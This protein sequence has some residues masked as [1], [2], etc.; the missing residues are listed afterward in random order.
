MVLLLVIDVVRQVFQLAPADG[1]ISVASL[2]KERAI[3]LAA[4]LNPRGGSFLNLLQ[5][6]MIQAFGLKKGDAIA[7]EQVNSLVFGI[8]KPIY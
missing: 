1:K 7:L 2:P 8:L 5:D 6:G 3:L 4:S